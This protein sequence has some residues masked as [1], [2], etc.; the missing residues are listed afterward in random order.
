MA[1]AGT[2]RTD[3]DRDGRM[4]QN[5]RQSNRTVEEML[6]QAAG[7]LAG[8]GAT[9]E[10]LKVQAPAAPPEHECRSTATTRQMCCRLLFDWQLH[11]L[12]CGS[13]S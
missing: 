12:R 4:L 10:T 3:I 11:S 13:I 5:V 9:R 2:S 7:V 8:M 6:D 1:G